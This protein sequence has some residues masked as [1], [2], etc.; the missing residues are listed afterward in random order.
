MT[1]LIAGTGD[2]VYEVIRPWGE[3]PAGMEFGIVSHVA[4]DSQ[5]RVYAFQR[6][7]PPI[8]VFDR[9]GKYL[10]SWGSGMFLG[11]P[12]HIHQRRRPHLPGHQGRPSGGQVHPGWQGGN[13]P[14]HGG[15]AL[16]SGS[17]QPPC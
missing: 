2:Y 1:K 14:G 12:R 4:V 15:G 7:D 9:G 6:Q 17:L 5:D 16:L 11:R 10:G 8:V 3:L 13:D